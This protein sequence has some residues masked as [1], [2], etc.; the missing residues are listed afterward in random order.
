M[1]AELKKIEVWLRQRGETPRSY[2]DLSKNVKGDSLVPEDLTTEAYNYDAVVGSFYANK[3]LHRCCSCDALLLK[4][5]LY[6]IEFKSSGDDVSIFG[7]DLSKLSQTQLKKIG[8]VL[9]KVESKL[10]ESLYML[11]NWILP[12]V[13]GLV[14]ECRFE[15][16]AIV[17]FNADENAASANAASRA[18]ASGQECEPAKKLYPRFQEKT[19]DGKPVFYHTVSVWPE[20]L[21][22]AKIRAVP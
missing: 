7:L 12:A 4:E 19:A 9:Y 21:F 15:K 3:T 22:S 11:K 20:N 16:H 5:H 8:N 1:N 2:R 13:T 6:L 17:V 18:S 14:D 10:S